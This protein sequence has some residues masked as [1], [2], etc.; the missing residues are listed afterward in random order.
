MVVVT[1]IVK[2][3]LASGVLAES[4]LR[5]TSVAKVGRPSVGLSLRAERAYFI[6]VNIG[7]RRSHFGSAMADGRLLEEHSVDT[8]A[9]PV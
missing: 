4:D 9:D 2:P 8:P 7:V 3:L 6:G 1:E 5:R